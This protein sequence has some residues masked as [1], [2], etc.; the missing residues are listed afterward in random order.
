[1]F[2]EFLVSLLKINDH[3][4][5]QRQNIGLHPSSPLERLGNLSIQRDPI[6][7]LRYPPIT[8]MGLL[9]HARVCKCTDDRDRIYALLSVASDSLDFP[10]DYNKN[11]TNVFI[12][13]AHHMITKEANLDFLGFTDGRRKLEGLPSWIPD[14]TCSTVPHPF[15][16]TVWSKNNPDPA[17]VEL[18]K[19][20]EAVFTV[21]DARALWRTINMYNASTGMERPSCYL[22]RQDPSSLVVRGY[23]LDQIASVD[24]GAIFADF[25]THEPYKHAC[26]S[27]VDALKTTASAGASASGALGMHNRTSWT[28]PD[29]GRVEFDLSTSIKLR[30]SWKSFL[31]QAIPG[32]ND[33]VANRTLFETSL[34]YIGLGSDRI[35]AGDSLCVIAGAQLPLVLRESNQT[36]NIFEFC[37][38]AY[39][40]GVMD[41]EAAGDSEEIRLKT[42][43]FV[44]R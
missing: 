41:G 29:Y 38:E 21:A 13:L 6:T 39:V 3:G 28:T 37:G 33:T 35:Q 27:R 23:K 1:M 26:C 11:T 9:E 5:K 2:D 15:P 43:K 31:L 10:V 17:L 40:H 18:V 36:E 25:S 14:W 24:S 12:D 16:K 19:K 8:A 44:I 22:N 32:L 7:S 34:G 4:R 20:K 30:V 42:R